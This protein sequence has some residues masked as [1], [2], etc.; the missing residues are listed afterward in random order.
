MLCHCSSTMTKGHFLVILYGTKLHVCA[1]VPLNPHLFIRY[2]QSVNYKT[3]F[4]QQ[5]AIAKYFL[6]KEASVRLY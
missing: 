3:T 2:I 6:T 5:I 4:K 1:G